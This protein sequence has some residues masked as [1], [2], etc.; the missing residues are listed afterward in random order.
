MS[1]SETRFVAALDSANVEKSMGKLG[2]TAEATGRSILTTIRQTAQMGIFLAQASGAAI[3]QILALQ[4]ETALIIAEVAV[5][6]IAVFQA[7]GFGAFL[8]VA[9]IKIG[10][11]LAL[12][13][14]M[15]VLIKRI[16]A[17]K[18]ESAQQTQGIVGALRMATFR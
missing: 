4:I 3:D 17:K 11:Q 14:S 9:G 10:A 8:G 18:A 6:S 2:K 1:T 13:I 12:I 5:A 16:K 7:G 15:L